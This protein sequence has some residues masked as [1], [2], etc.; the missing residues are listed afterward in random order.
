LA[1]LQ[2]SSQRFRVDGPLFTDL[3]YPEAAAPEVWDAVGHLNTPH[4]SEPY[5]AP[6][7][8]D[9]GE[10]LDKKTRR[11]LWILITVAGIAALAHESLTVALANAHRDSALKVAHAMLTWPLP[12]TQPILAGLA[13]FVLMGMAVQ[14][15]GWRQVTARQ[16]RLLLGFIIAAI[17]GAAP[18][19]LFCLLTVAIFLLI[20]TFGLVFLLVLFLLLIVAR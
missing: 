10:G 20:I 4:D 19:V 11:F 5:R 12:M 3:S 2:L 17:L 15:N 9:P 13:T 8:G 16:S 6:T 18:L 7:P 1:H 14:T